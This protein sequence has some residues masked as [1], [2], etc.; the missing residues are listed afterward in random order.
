MADTDVDPGMSVAQDDG[1][2][3][4]SLDVERRFNNT[5]AIQRR[6]RAWHTPLLAVLVAC[7]AGVEIWL[8]C[9]PSVPWLI[10]KLYYIV[11]LTF[12]TA[13]AISL[14]PGVPRGLSAKVIDLCHWAFVILVYAGALLLRAVQSLSLV[15]CLALA[16]VL[17]RLFM[18]NTCIIT[19]VAGRE[20]RGP[21]ISRSQVTWVFSGL[22]II[23]ALRLCLMLVFWPGF[24]Y[25]IPDGA[26]LRAQDAAG[27]K[28]QASWETLLT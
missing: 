27:R 21:R 17:L 5:E 10:D 25:Y 14:V 24:P 4:P 6:H 22:F 11:C 16:S 20:F 23:S 13:L 18:Q 9:T 7:V 28:N 2:E 3:E 8:V 26:R 12:Q 1:K 19:T 15:A